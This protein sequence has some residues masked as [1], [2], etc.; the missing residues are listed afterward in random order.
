MASGVKK[1][2]YDGGFPDP[3]KGFLTAEMLYLS[4]FRDFFGYSSKICW[5]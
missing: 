4:R 3:E 2:A 5:R 1:A